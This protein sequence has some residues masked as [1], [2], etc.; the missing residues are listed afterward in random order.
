ME[1]GIKAMLVLIKILKEMPSMVLQEFFIMGML[2]KVSSQST[3]VLNVVPRWQ[4]LK[5][6][7]SIKIQQQLLLSLNL[8]KTALKN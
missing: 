3:G 7:I 2:K 6:N 4:K 5:L 8:M 1:I